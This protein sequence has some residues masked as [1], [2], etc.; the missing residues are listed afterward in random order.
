MTAALVA[1]PGSSVA[2]DV[3]FSPDGRTL[4]AT[5]RADG[6]VSLWEATPVTP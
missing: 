6:V 1:G 5:C 2:Q 3:A 4:A